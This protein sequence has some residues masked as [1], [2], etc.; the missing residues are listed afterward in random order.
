MTVTY[1]A[2]SKVGADD[3]ADAVSM[4]LPKSLLLVM[5]LRVQLPLM[6]QLSLPYRY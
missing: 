6:R 3:D 2:D 1:D 5:T 4:P